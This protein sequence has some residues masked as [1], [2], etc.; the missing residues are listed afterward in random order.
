MTQRQEKINL[1][2]Y[3]VNSGDNIDSPRS[4]VAMS[5]LGFTVRDIKLPNK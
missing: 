1:D 3:V 5:Q 4:V 2:N